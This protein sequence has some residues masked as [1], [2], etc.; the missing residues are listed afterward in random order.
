MIFFTAPFIYFLF[1]ASCIFWSIPSIRLRR[2]FLILTG[3][4]ALGWVQPV[5]TSFLFLV[6]GTIHAAMQFQRRGSKLSIFWMLILGLTLVL[7]MLKYGMVQFGDF[8]VHEN[9]F[10]KI[11]LVPLG[12]SY[13]IFRLISYVIDCH[14]GEVVQ[15]NFE[16]L[17]CYVFFVPI[18][19]A[20]PIERYKTFYDNQ[21]HQFDPAL[22]SDGLL[23]LSLGLFKKIVLVNFFLQRIVFSDQS[24][25][26]NSNQDFSGVII[27]CFLIGARMPALTLC[28]CRHCDWF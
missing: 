26:L 19:T 28:L 22:Y 9:N 21:K 5:F 6:T 15:Q 27:I 20:G 18:F 4:F 8:F 25:L 11:Y 13:I 3:A 14:R 24:P 16:N 7:I 12:L 23:R 2:L 10:S 17:I 1:L